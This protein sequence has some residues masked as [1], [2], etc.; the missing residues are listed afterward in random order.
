[1]LV[2]RYTFSHAVPS[3]FIFNTKIFWTPS[4]CPWFVRLPFVFAPASPACA[5]Y[6]PPSGAYVPP[7][8][9]HQRLSLLV[10]TW[11]NVRPASWETATYDASL[12]LKAT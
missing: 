1:M 11:E 9:Y 7:Y 6:T 12:T 10:F 2:S 3:W 5:K 8:E 4:V